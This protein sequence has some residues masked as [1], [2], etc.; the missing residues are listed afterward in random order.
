MYGPAVFRFS[1]TFNSGTW[2]DQMLDLLSR[3]AELHTDPS[4]SDPI[5]LSPDYAYE[6]LPEEDESAPEWTPETVGLSENGSSSASLRLDHHL[7]DVDGEWPGIWKDVGIFTEE[8]F[9]G[10]MTTCLKTMEGTKH[11]T[12]KHADGKL[13][14]TMQ[15]MKKPS[16]RVRE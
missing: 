6:N 13:S 9:R 3:L 16:D 5:R 12:G 14:D 1:A 15:K 4:V 10:I 8:E 11:G 2:D 7:I